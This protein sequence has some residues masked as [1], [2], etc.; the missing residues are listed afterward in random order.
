[1]QHD[2]TAL[3]SNFV[4]VF[5]KLFDI[6]VPQLYPRL[7]TGVLPLSGDEPEKL[8]TSANLNGLPQVFHN[9]RPEQQ[10]CRQTEWQVRAE[11]GGR[12]LPRKSSTI[13]KRNTAYGNK[14]TGKMLES[15]F[16][17]IGYGWER[18]P[19]RLGLAVLFRGGA[20]RK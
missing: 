8:L 10:S 5:H 6:V 1:M 11:S 7:E 13:S 4:E 15:H 17:G 12:P 14:V 20:V 18:D 3:G 16:S 9:D 2:A 19:I